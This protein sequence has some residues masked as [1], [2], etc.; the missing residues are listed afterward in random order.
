MDDA[1]RAVAVVLER[2][3]HPEPVDVGQGR[4]SHGLSLKLPP[5]R[6][7]RLLAA[8]DAGHDAGLGQDL[9]DL[10]GHDLGGAA[11]FELQRLQ[12]TLDGGAGGGVQV[13]E[14]EFLK[15]RRD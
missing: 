6:I 5:D 1:Q 11:V 10:V 14:G 3:D 4:E 7:G 13:L 12:T 15:L 9:F 8:E 2:H